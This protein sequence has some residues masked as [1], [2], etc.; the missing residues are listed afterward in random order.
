MYM[1]ICKSR[2]VYIYIYI[3]S[4]YLIVYCIFYPEVVA[5][6]PSRSGHV[7]FQVGSCVSIQGVRIRIRVERFVGSA[8][9]NFDRCHDS[10]Q[11]SCSFQ[12][13]RVA[14]YSMGCCALLYS[15]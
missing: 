9:G 6:E 3:R 12:P 5:T 11:S 10:C 14:E 8:H 7:S 15:D 4:I 13:G 1:Y 2:Y